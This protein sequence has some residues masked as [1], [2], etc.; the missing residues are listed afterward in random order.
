MRAVARTGKPVIVSV[1]FA[2]VEEVEFSLKTLRESGATEVIVLHCTTSYSPE[3]AEGAT[4]LRTMQDTAD[5]FDVAVGFSD[6]MGGIKIPALAAAMG[7]V[8]IE[9]HLVL[10][11]NPEIFDDRF[12]LDI[13]EFAEMVHLIRSQEEAM[14]SVNYGPRT[15]EEEHNKRFRRSLFA[16]KDIKRG[17]RFTMEN[18]RSVRPA[19]GLETKYIDQVLESHAASDIEFGTPL[20]LDLLVNDDI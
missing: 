8:V 1:G 4:H 11:H 20:S 17:E 12:S 2:M 18:V 10:N 5:R 16:S 19:D 6:N 7:A 3:G 13:D 14:G 15:K 9:K